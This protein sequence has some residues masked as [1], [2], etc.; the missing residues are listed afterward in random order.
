MRRT[1]SSR[2]SVV[3]LPDERGLPPLA[4]G[5]LLGPVTRGVAGGG[6]DALGA[7]LDL[8]VGGHQVGEGFDGVGQSHV[9]PRMYSLTLQ[10]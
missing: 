10:Q 3:L 2:L 8:E 1:F 6:L 5:F 7:A 4:G 9:F